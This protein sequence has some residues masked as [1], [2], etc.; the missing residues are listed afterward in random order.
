[1]RSCRA[2]MRRKSARWRR[3]TDGV[4]NGPA[5]YA[6]IFAVILVANTASSL[7]GFGGTVLALPFVAMIIGVK[8]AVPVLVV[9]AWVL[10]I[11]ICAEARRSISWRDW[12]K[13]VVFVVLGLPVGLWVAGVVREEPLKLALGLFTLALGSYGMI[14]PLPREDS[15]ERLVG[16]KRRALTGLLALGGVVHGAFAT[17]GPLIVVYGTRAMPEKST[18]RVTMSAT[19]LTLNTILLTQWFIRG[20][21]TE[22]QLKLAALCV[23]FTLAGMAIGTVAHYRVDELLFRR[24]LYTVLIIASLML[25]GSA[26]GVG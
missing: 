10:A 4:V 23:P 3:W 8:M 19:W 7:T 13:I 26:V 21:F 1:M 5:D 22:P 16:W 9:Q 24:A 11:F 12:A 18:F 25:I 14:R 20:T 6:L 17:G 2:A 15:R